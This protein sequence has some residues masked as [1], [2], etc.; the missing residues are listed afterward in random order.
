MKVVNDNCQP[1]KDY[2]DIE[3][4]RVYMPF[5]WMALLNLFFLTCCTVTKDL[6]FD[7]NFCKS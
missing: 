7:V 4:F 1:T 5:V 6:K 3:L 2:L